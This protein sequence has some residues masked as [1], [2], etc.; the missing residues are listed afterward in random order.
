MSSVQAFMRVPRFL[1]LVLLLSACA[2]HPEKMPAYSPAPPPLAR[3]IPSP[4]EAQV[5]AASSPPPSQTLDLAPLPRLTLSPEASAQETLYALRFLEALN[6]L[7]HARKL[8]PERLE[9]IFNEAILLQEYGTQFE[10]QGNS[11]A[12]LRAGQLYRLFIARAGE[13]PE[14]QEALRAAKLRLSGIEE[15]TICNFRESEA[16]RKKRQA[17]EMQRRAEE[18]AELGQN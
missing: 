3:P 15:A 5:S 16:E 9:A 4:I 2:A 13:D 14:Y 6:T 17:E 18:E 11:T 7:E 10:S 1:P 12:L 8:E